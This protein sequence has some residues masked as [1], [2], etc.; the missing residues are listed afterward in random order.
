M[1]FKNFEYDLHISSPLND[2]ER[3]QMDSR[4]RG[5]DSGGLQAWTPARLYCF[6]IPA[7]AG[8]DIF[9]ALNRTSR[10]DTF[11]PLKTGLSTTLRCRIAT[12]LYGVRIR[13]RKGSKKKNQQVRE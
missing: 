3:K 12:T 4:F 8:M 5:N 9:A 6:W 2:L 7:F 13:S 1:K 11:V 10:W